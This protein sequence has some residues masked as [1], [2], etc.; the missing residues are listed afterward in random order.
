VHI[1]AA[2]AEHEATMISARTK[3]ALAA[4]RVR[5]V[6]LGGQRGSRDRMK[7]IGRKGNVASASARREAA[8]KRNEDLIPVINEISAAGVSTP[9]KIAEALNKRGITAARGGAWGTVQVRRVLASAP[10]QSGQN[11]MGLSPESRSN[12]A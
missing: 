2:V 7:I 11:L 4:A 3:A 10:P 9:A 6:T 8:C 5:G 1:L 12:S